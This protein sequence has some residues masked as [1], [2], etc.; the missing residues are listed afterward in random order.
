MF[1]ECSFTPGYLIF[2]F[3]V[4]SII[5]FVPM[6]RECSFTVKEDEITEWV[7]KFST[8]FRPYV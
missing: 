3:V 8:S 6:F 7:D 5:V 4:D 2:V 1:R